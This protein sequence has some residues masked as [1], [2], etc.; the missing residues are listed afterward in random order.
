MI[1]K[2]LKVP[3]AYAHSEGS[4]LKL[5]ELALMTGVELEKVDRAESVEKFNKGEAM[6]LI[7]TSCIS[8]G[9]NIYP[10]R[11]TCNWVGGGSEI[12][13]KQGA[14][15]R[16]VRLFEQ[17]PFAHLCKKPSTKTIVDFNVYD[18]YALKKML[19]D[20]C[21]FYRDSGTEIRRIKLK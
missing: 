19:E 10:M 1:I 9:T 20:R 6:V 15:G 14:V 16:T 8:T 11:Y 18:A 12:R 3:Y 2:L 21:L 5:A 7:G 17:N 4:K 13:T